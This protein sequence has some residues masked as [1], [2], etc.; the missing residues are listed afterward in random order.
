MTVGTEHDGTHFHSMIHTRQ[1]HPP[2]P[3]CEKP[4]RIVRV[5]SAFQMLPEIRVFQ[6]ESCLQNQTQVMTEELANSVRL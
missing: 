2:C 6:C 1:L 4:M 5:F 3:L